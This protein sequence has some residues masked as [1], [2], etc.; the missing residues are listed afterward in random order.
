[1]IECANSITVRGWSAEGTIC[2]VESESKVASGADQGSVGG[3]FGW[4]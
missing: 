2:T 4:M 1:M 3:Q